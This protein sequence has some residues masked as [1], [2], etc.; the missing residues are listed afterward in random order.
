MNVFRMSE[1]VV[2]HPIQCIE[3]G[4]TP[5]VTT[6]ATGSNQSSERVEQFKCVTLDS[7]E[8]EV[9]KISD[10]ICVLIVFNYLHKV[11]VMAGAASEG[12]DVSK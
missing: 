7:N 12:D 5:M 6:R 4:H 3:I 2:E 8:Q 9:F 10:Y 1:P 11:T